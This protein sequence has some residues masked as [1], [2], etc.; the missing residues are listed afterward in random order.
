M[1]DPHDA[2]VPSFPGTKVEVWFQV[3]TAVGLDDRI[4]GEVVEHL[5]DIYVRHP[6]A[7]VYSSE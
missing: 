7:H 3:Y 2:T 6:G 4:E 5:P 1:I